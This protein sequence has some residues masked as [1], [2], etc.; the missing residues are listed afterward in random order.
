VCS[1]TNTGPLITL[2]TGIL[3]RAS[4]N[5]CSIWAGS[6][7]DLGFKTFDPLMALNAHC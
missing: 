2:I 5:S 3:T 7:L 6:L 1:R 4:C